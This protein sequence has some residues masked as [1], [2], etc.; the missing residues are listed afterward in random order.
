[1][2]NSEVNRLGD[3]LRQG[4]L[5]PHLLSQLDEYRRSFQ[6]PIS[7]VVS[8]I[9]TELVHVPELAI[10]TLRPS[11]A[12]PSI[13]AKL[14][15]QPT[16]KLSQIQDIAGLR[17]LAM[18]RKSQNVWCEEIRKLFPEGKLSDRREKPSFGYRALHL[19]V[20]RLDKAVEI[21]IRTRLQHMWAE[22]S[23]RIADKIGHEFKYGLSSSPLYKEMLA[24]SDEIDN[25]ELAQLDTDSLGGIG[26]TSP[27][28]QRRHQIELKLRLQ[29]S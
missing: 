12:T 21:Q 15:R 9:R 4:D 17:L 19:V 25:F 18:D 5:T 27:L 13:V 20:K 3:L 1:M 10:L 29:S 7:E 26:A 23:E 16:L 2:N 14:K 6:A 8:S 22:L 11:K 28:Q 24:L